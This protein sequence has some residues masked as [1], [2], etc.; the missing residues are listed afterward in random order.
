MISILDAAD[1]RG[2]LAFARR[3]DHQRH[4]RAS[5]SKLG[6]IVP[7]FNPCLTVFVQSLSFFFLVTAVTGIVPICIT[8]SARRRISLDAN[9]PL[10]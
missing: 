3:G 2:I 9:Q 7:V 10:A 1:T 5:K 6:E 8:R 4:H